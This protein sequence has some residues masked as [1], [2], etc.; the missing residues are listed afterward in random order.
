MCV[1]VCERDKKNLMTCISYT[2]FT[3]VYSITKQSRHVFF[4]LFRTLFKIS[5]TFFS[6]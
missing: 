1:C 4:K 2:N 5:A 3:Y 6:F